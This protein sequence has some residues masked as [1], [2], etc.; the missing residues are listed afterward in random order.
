M[1]LV[2]ANLASENKEYLAKANGSTIAFDGFYKVYRESVDDDAEEENKMLPPLKEQESLKTK[3]VIPNQH[4]TEPPP[5]YSEAS[6]VKKLEE[7]GIGRPSTYASILSVLQDRKYV[8]LEKKRFIPEE[9]GRLVTV[10]LVGFFTKYVEYDFTAGLENELD[11]IAAGKLEWKAA[12]NNFW[13]GFNHNIESVNEQ[14][15]T[16][17]I[18]YVQKALDYHLFGENKESKV[19]PSCNTGELSLKLGKFGAFLACSNYPECTFRKS[20]VSGND[21]NENEASLPLCLMRIKF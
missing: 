20:I 14:K 4:F 7:L 13:S 5:R 12:L 19:C 16:E 11:E 6:L 1:D 21:N 15:I 9:L 10:F 8:A 17:I 2:V 3:E 18:S